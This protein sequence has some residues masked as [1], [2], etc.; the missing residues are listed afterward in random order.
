MWYLL[1][2]SLTVTTSGTSPGV[3]VQS[4]GAGSSLEF[5]ESAAGAEAGVWWVGR[6]W[7]L[8]TQGRCHNVLAQSR[9]PQRLQTRPGRHWVLTEIGPSDRSGAWC[10]GRTNGCGV[11]GTDVQEE[12]MRCMGLLFWMYGSILF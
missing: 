7:G 3:R 4:A 2:R 10:T 5:G 9:F 6:W 8:L 11:R 1:T 12:E